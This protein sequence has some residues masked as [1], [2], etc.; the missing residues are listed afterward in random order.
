MPWKN[1]EDKKA[2]YLRHRDHFIAK[3]KINRD[4]RYPELLEY[5][6]AKKNVPC[7]DCGGIFPPICMDFDHVKGDKIIHIS[8]AVARGWAIK[9]IQAEIDKCEVVCANCHRIRTFSDSS[10][11]R[12]KPKPFKIVHSTAQSK[13]RKQSA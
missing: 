10:P 5:V 9:R 13:I 4:R 12:L 7:V 8:G 2:Y 6:R 11:D 1:P 3:A